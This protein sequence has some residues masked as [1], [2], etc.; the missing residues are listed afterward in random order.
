MPEATITYTRTKDGHTVW[1]NVDGKIRPIGEVLHRGDRHWA[2]TLDGADF[3]YYPSMSQAG[4]RL[5]RAY[6]E[7]I[8]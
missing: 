3:G 7:Q 1:R 5:N 2:V 8:G 6:E 4:E